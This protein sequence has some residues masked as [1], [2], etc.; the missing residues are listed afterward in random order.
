[1][2]LHARRHARL[3]PA[4][5]AHRQRWTRSAGKF[6]LHQ[7]FS[8]SGSKRGRTDEASAVHAGLSPLVS[9]VTRFTR[10][11]LAAGGL[12]ALWGWA[13]TRLIAW[14]LFRRSRLRATGAPAQPTDS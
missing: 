11:A 6:R 10:G 4:R 1:M 12:A 8:G 7:R 13:T 3:F 5:E 2:G 9:G 14:S